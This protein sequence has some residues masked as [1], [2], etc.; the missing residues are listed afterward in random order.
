MTEPDAARQRQQAD[1]DGDQQRAQHFEADDVAVD[2]E[3]L[4]PHEVG[5][6]GEGED[7][8]RGLGHD[9]RIAGAAADRPDDHRDDAGDI[10]QHDADVAER[11]VVGDRPVQREQDRKAGRDPEMGRQEAHVAIG[12][13]QRQR[14]LERVVEIGEQ[15][16]AGDVLHVQ[17]PVAH[18][19]D[20]AEQPGDAARDE[21]H[22]LVL[23]A[24][25]QRH[26]RRGEADGEGKFRQ[27]Q[28][29]GHAGQKA[30]TGGEDAGLPQRPLVQPPAVD[31][32]DGDRRQDGDAHRVVVIGRAEHVEAQPAGLA[33]QRQRGGAQLVF[34]HRQGLAPEDVERHD[35]RPLDAAQREQG[36]PRR[37]VG[38]P[39]G[40]T[41]CP[42]TGCSRSP[43]APRACRCA[44]ARSGRRRGCTSGNCG[45]PR[46]C[47]CPATG[48][49]GPRTRW[50]RP[51][52]AIPAAQASRHAN[53]HC[54][55][56]WGRE[57]RSYEPGRF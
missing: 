29:D 22:P 7:G 53:R 9:Q 25:A 36:E 17:R 48:R 1:R 5:H 20:D 2:R 24:S 15:R 23:P 55:P 39:A 52:T 32:Q 12:G 31:H 14:R 43:G 49:K 13:R 11:D 27:L 46:T 26:Q 41:E 16:V 51:G 8:A 34:L 35:I 37:R 10:G 57:G 6:R 56:A 50:R 4:Q 45:N 40:R 3:H 28:A 38:R 19:Q 33:Q 42:G 30:R 21:A 18:H 47:P 54:L 44:R